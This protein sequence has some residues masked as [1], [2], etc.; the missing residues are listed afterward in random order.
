MSRWALRVFAPVLLLMPLVGDAG[1]INISISNSAYDDLEEAND[2]LELLREI[3]VDALSYNGA[4]QVEILPIVNVSGRGEGSFNDAFSEFLANEEQLSEIEAFVLEYGG[5]EMYQDLENAQ[6]AVQVLEILENL[7]ETVYL[8]AGAPLAAANAA[9]GILTAAATYAESNLG[10]DTGRRVLKYGKLLREDECVIV[11][12]VGRG[13]IIANNVEAQLI[14]SGDI[15]VDE[16]KYQTIAVGPVSARPPLTGEYV[17]DSG[18]LWR[19][20]PPFFPFTPEDENTFGSPAFLGDALRNYNAGAT[21]IRIRGLIID[22]VERARLAC[23]F[24]ITDIVYTDIIN[25]SL[26]GTPVPLNIFWDGD[27]KYPVRTHSSFDPDCRSFDCSIAALGEVYV[28]GNTELFTTPE[29]PLIHLGRCYGFGASP[30]GGII[31][32]PDDVSVYFFLE[33]ATGVTTNSVL[34]EYNCSYRR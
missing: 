10:G 5:S 23:G 20:Y 6:T 16:N 22:A 4:P 18:D 11:V 31:I 25:T 8:T 7:R 1:K 15:K 26:D 24:R 12:S 9:I 2:D 32:S 33:D 3:V 17:V 14:A 13:A 30:F 19:N 29:Q 27:A 21:G 34:V 28:A